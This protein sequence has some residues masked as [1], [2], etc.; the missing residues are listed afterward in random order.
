MASI[1]LSREGALQVELTWSIGREH[2]TQLLPAIDGLLTRLGASQNDLSAVFV[3]IGPG[4][5]AGVRAG[6]STAK[7][8]AFGL[9]LPLVG[10]CRLEVDAYG[11][12]AVGGRIVAVHRAGRNEAAWASYA[13]S[14]DWRET[15]PPR[16][17]AWEDLAEALPENALVTGELEEDTATAISK[18]G[19]RVVT[20]A[21][22]IR[23]AALLAELGWQRLSAG[24]TDDPKSLVPIYLREPAIGP[25]PMPGP[26]K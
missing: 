9:E 23:R 12:R 18:R 8:L 2:S 16:L 20:G 3:S 13:A 26:Q 22:T 14:P 4:R 19:H 7:G 17:T 10:V 25:Q 21:A 1:A 5:Y 15:S 11:W 24:E 6:V